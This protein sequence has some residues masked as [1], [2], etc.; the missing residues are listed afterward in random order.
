MRKIYLILLALV[1]A[2]TGFSQTYHNLSGAAFTQNWTNIGMITANDDWSGVPG[3]IGYRG[4]NIT[5][6]TGAD[7]QTLVGEGTITVDVNANQT[8][9]NTF[10]TGGVTEFHITD[11][12]VALSGSGTADAPNIVIFLN[13]TGASNIR[14]QYNLRDIDGSVDDAVQPVALQYR[15]GTSGNF[16]NLP[17]A[18]VADASS[19]PSLATLVTAVDITLPVACENQA[20]LQ[21]RIISNN[22]VGNDEWIGIDDINI[23]AT[24]GPALP[25]VTVAAGTTLAEPATPGGF[26]L[27]LTLPAPAG[28]L[29]VNYTIGGTAAAGTDYAALSGT[30]FIPEA[31][32]SV[33][34]PV[35]VNDDVIIDPD[36]TVTLTLNTGTGYSVGIPNNTGLTITDNEITNLYIYNFNTCGGLPVDGF[37][38]FSA[39]GP[40]LWGCTTF[41]RDANNMPTGSAANGLQI[42]GYDN[43]IPSNVLN[44]DWLISPS[45][46]LTA[47]TYPLLSFYSRTRFNGGPLQLKVSTNYSG[48]D[49]ALATWTD[50]NGRFPNQTSDVWTLTSYV[51]LS[52]FKAANVH[53]AFVYTSTNET[54]ARWT[55]DD[56]RLDNAA[57]PPPASLTVST[58]DMQ[59]GFAAAGNTVTRTFTVSGNDI[60]GDITLNTGYVFSLSTDGV[61]FSPSITLTQ[62]AANN[63]L[64]TIYARFAPAANSI[65]YNGA[66]TISTSGV[67]NA[68][69]NLNGTSVDTANTLEVVNWNIEWFGSTVS[70]QGPAN[71]AQQ[72]ANVQTILQAVKAD[73]Y[74][75]VEVVDES[76]LAAVVSNM[77]GYAYVINNYGSH[78]NPNAPSP[79]PLAEA[80]KLAFVYRTSV[81]SNISTAPLLSQG[82]NSLADI[83]NPA[84]NYFASGRFPYMMTA[85][86]T[87]NGVT[88][89]VRFVLVH[90]KANTSPTA[91]SYARRK[92]GADT[93]R[94]TL[95]TLYPADNIVILGD[96][97]DD[98]DKTITDGMPT[99]TT[100]YIAFIK[101][102]LNFY[103]PTLALSLAGKKSTVTY[104][105]MIDHVIL[106]TEMRNYYMNSTSAV[107]S[108]VSSLVTNYGGTTTDHYPIFT[109]YAF[110][111]LILPVVLGSFTAEKQNTKVKLDWITQQETNSR[112][113]EVQRSADGR[114]WSTIAVVNAAGNA[115][116]VNSYSAFDDA[117]A[118]GANL[119]RLAMV[120]ADGRKKYSDTRLIRF[121]A[122]DAVVIYPNPVKNDLHILLPLPNAQ[123]EIADAA[124]KTVYTTA[125][126]G[127]SL[128][129]PAATLAPGVYVIKINSAAGPVTRKFIKQ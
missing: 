10:A 120:D 8:A 63:A 79:S 14:V 16:I 126:A 2:L 13:T 22:A 47:T 38:Q 129:V 6:A 50:L 29:T 28:G 81:F 69:V 88:R 87:L 62:A 82:I 59:F 95:N 102:S 60:T 65:N 125:A 37:T 90:A 58:A 77:P 1:C 117:P 99:D 115:Q 86:V 73:L 128:T 101:D 4:D 100:S 94:Q 11:P 103:P 56:I 78:T 41:G 5:G 49:P 83:T 96:L 7:P 109:R 42:N 122:A 80:Q 121:D 17:G 55:L 45:Y 9:P 108:D 44:E 110:D 89:T 116:V 51:N 64:T 76:R 30:V 46:D 34:I 119:Y 118:K 27:N 26:N 20:Q 18:F 98:L 107:L 105:D 71:D 12:V 124:G 36:E 84:Y 52:A 72:Q 75:L 92:A 112:A 31:A 53:I 70:G 23:T 127:T 33:S 85:D 93:L 61:S 74:G 67:S 111:P 19:G 97:N 39:I 113:F 54:G 106:S 32:T 68:I 66:V 3:I 57:I 43:S 21:L 48:G 114:S 123:I 25:V 40:Q 91:T 104:A 15:I 24:G 35:T